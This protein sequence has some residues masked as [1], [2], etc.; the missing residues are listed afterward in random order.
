MRAFEIAGGSVAGA[1]HIRAARNNHDAF[2]WAATEDGVIAVVCDGCGS[3]PHSEVGAKI[4]ARLAVRTIAGHLRDGI[5]WP[6]VE[7]NFIQRLRSV[8]EQVGGVAD[9]FLFTLVAA[10][11]TRETTTV[12]AAGDGVAMINGV[13]VPF[14]DVVD[15]APA[16]LGYALLGKSDAS[17]QP[18]ASVPTG[19]VRSLLLATDGAAQLDRLATFWTDDRYFRNPDALRRALFVLNRWPPGKLPDDTTIVVIRRRG[20]DAGTPPQ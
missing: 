7:A 12:A 3:A 2:R 11:I 1:D 19:D 10:V 16:Y 9:F 6:A 15:N 8:A 14:P 17:L 5:D 18:L 20:T 4:G 13:S